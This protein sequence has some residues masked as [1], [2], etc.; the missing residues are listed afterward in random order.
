MMNHHTP[1]FDFDL[2]PTVAGYKATDTSAA[3]ARDITPET[4]R[5]RLLV[6]ND[7]AAQREHGSTSEEI[8]ERTGVP[9]VS[10]QPRTSEL[11]RLGK[12]VDSGKRRP[13]PSSGK[14]AIVWVLRQFKRGGAA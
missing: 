6:L 8:V 12:I 5:L 13:N 10:I 7:I 4:G 14:Q 1:E 3:A 9:R 2:Y 11:R